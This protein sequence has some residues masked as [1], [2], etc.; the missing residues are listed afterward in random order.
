M[1]VGAYNT[2][3]KEVWF[4]YGKR[5]ETCNSE[6][7]I[8]NVEHPFVSIV[9]HGFSAFLEARPDRLKSLRSWLIDNCICTIGELAAAGQ[10]FVDEGGFCVQEGQPPCSIRP[11]YFYTDDP[12][13]EGDDYTTENCAAASPHPASLY[14][15]LGDLTVE[16]LCGSEFLA[17][18]CGGEKIFLMVSVDDQGIKQDS[19]VYFRERIFTTEGC[20]TYIKD[21]YRTLLRSG[22]LNFGLPDDAKVVN[23]FVIDIE[24]APESFPASFA[25]RLG[26]SARP[27][28]PNTA[29]GHNVIR[30]FDEDPKLLEG[31]DEV[32]AATHEEE[33]TAP[34][35]QF[36]WP[37]LVKG[38]WIYFQIE[39]SNPSTV[40]V[41]QGGAACWSEYRLYAIADERNY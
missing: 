8:I 21:G 39:I 31:L 30:W 17:D 4:S 38:M 10:A 16:D 22:P 35:D 7:M 28:D 34:D 11:L 15:M 27:L 14:A 9:D 1:A 18:Q 36:E 5:G 25:V 13:H 19:E 3:R 32:D 41:D 29:S 20:G 12:I 2:T 26:A 40:P 24:P 23:G 33:N 6:T 37:F